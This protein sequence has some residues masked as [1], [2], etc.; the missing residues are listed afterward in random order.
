MRSRSGTWWCSRVPDRHDVSRETSLPE[1]ATTPPAPASAQGVFGSGRLAL[2]EKYAALLADAGVVRGLIG[3]REVPRLWERHLLNCAV[4]TDLV[5]EGAT[6]ADIGTGA[7]LPGVVLAIARPD[8]TVT[9]VDPLLRRTTFLEEA[10]ES[11]QLDNCRVVRARAEELQGVLEVDVVTARA[12]APLGRLLEWAMPLV[13][14]KGALLA[15]KGSRAREEIEAA[16]A[17]VRR[18][19][20]GAPEVL[21]LGDGIVDPPTTVVRVARATDAQVG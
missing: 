2:A 13:S 15:M 5:P 17:V 20:C 16:R 11:L 9:L 10:V 4:L 6:V 21:T 18:L 8:L 19:R 14:A 3:P 12:V 7:G 1:E